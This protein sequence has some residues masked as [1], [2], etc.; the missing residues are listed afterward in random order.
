[1]NAV[2]SELH[3]GIREA[4]SAYIDTVLSVGLI[5]AASWL[6]VVLWTLARALHSYYR[7]HHEGHAFLFGLILFGLINAFT[8]SG[9]I[10]PM[11]VPF[12]ALSGIMHHAF[13]LEAAPGPNRVIVPSKVSFAYPS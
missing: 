13:F 3:W 4:H 7:T 10:M 6:V 9:M 11:F 12:V 8:E 1:V 5:G 2:S